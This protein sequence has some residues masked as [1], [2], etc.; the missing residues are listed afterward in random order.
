MEK[1]GDV[2][3]NLQPDPLVQT[4]RPDPANIQDVVALDGYLG[5][6][7]GGKK[8]L[9]SDLSLNLGVEIDPS[10]IVHRETVSGGGVPDYS[11]VWVRR[12][13]ELT[14]VANP[15]DPDLPGFLANPFTPEDLLTQDPADWPRT[16]P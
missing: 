5:D 13:V 16:G 15:Q 7:P 6:G 1:E 10:D 4:L 2:S 8:L 12:G 14:A 3:P 9:Y 11:V